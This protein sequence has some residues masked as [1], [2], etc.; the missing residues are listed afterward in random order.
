MPFVRLSDHIYLVGGKELSHP[1]DCNVYLIDGR[2]QDCVLVDS[3]TGLGVDAILRNVD[4]AGFDPGQVAAVVNTHCHYCHAGGN[5]WLNLHLGYIE[6][7]IH[8][9]D[10]TAV[11]TDDSKLTGA[12]LHS[13]RFEPCQVNV[14]VC[15]SDMEPMKTLG[16]G[17]RLLISA[18]RFELA[19]I[20]T[21][22]HTPGSMSL[23]GKIDGKQTLFAGDIRDQ[24]RT[25]WG[26][27]SESQRSSIQSLLEIEIDRIFLR[28]GTAVEKPREW[29]EKSIIN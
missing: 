19:P 12:G 20:H 13:N 18:G 27:N 22:G 29:L 6:V 3:G 7:I 1:F 15:T 5:F 25:E 4:E 23:Y 8:E 17:D 28:H 24:L 2:P 10:A 26:S 9:L 14:R 11:E 16:F 21:P